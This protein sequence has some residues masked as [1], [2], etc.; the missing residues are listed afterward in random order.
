[1]DDA[2]ASQPTPDT[3]TT[4]SA[5]EV[6]DLRLLAVLRGASF[7]GDNVALVTL[8]LRL[9]PQGHAWEIAALSIA[10]ALPLVVLAPVAGHVVDRVR[11]K[12]LLIA[13]G[14]LEALVCVAIG[15]WHSL[16]ATLSLVALLSVGVSFSMPGYGV[17]M[18]AIAGD[19]HVGRAQSLMQ[20]V[21][22]AATVAGPILGG[23]LVG[24]TGQSWP[25][26]LDAMSFALCALGTAAITRDRQPSDARERE[27]PQMTAG[28]RHIFADRLLRPIVLMVFIFITSVVMVNVAEVFF[29]TRTLHASA[30]LYGAIGASFGFGTIAGSL[31]ASR[32]DHSPLRLARTMLVSIGI[33]ALAIGAVGLVTSIVWVYP[34]MIIAGAAIGVVNVAAFTLFTVRTPEEIRGRM[35]AAVNAVFTSGELSSTVLGGLLLTLVAPRTVFQIAGVVSTLCIVI[36]GPFALAGTRNA[37]HRE[38]AQGA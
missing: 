30:T 4:M 3:P 37:H 7:L 5:S 2:V 28:L 15:Y 14:L 38:I 32:L 36:F 9:V 33:T 25:L 1:M 19:D 16:D 26:Y 34:L 22:G 35:F 10:S 12:P 20:G 6:R 13:L 17:L 24:W 31:G 27:H 29:A 8:Y 21:Q 23:L 11:V 18:V